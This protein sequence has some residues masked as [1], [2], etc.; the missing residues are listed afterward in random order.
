M[1][2]NICGLPHRIVEVEDK[3]DTDCHM[4]QI[5]YKELKILVNKDMPKDLKCATICHEMLHGML[6]HL[7]YNNLSNDEQFVTALGNAIYQSFIVD[8]IYEEGDN[9]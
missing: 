2:V 3:F 8:L 1:K 6:T 9:V 4:G 7:G 5:N